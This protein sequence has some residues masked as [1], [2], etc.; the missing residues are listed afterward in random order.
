MSDPTS[1]QHY[2]QG[3]IECID[4]IRA[5][6]GPAGFAA[7]CHGNI[8]KYTWRYRHKNGLEDLKKA[9]VYLGWLIEVTPP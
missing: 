5:A 4:A 8:L 1:P 3:G 7:Y 6:L 2:Q 9:Q